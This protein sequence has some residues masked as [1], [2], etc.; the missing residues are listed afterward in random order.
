MASNFAFREN[1]KNKYD[2]YLYGASYP[3]ITLKSKE[4]A[5]EWVKLFRQWDKL[6]TVFVKSCN[7]IGIDEDDF[8]DI[9]DTSLRKQITAEQFAD[10][11]KEFALQSFQLIETSQLIHSEI[12]KLE[13]TNEAN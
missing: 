6:R 4:A 1:K 12:M 2:C 13:K 9:I 7:Q 5:Q 10:K 11:M 8:E 3:T